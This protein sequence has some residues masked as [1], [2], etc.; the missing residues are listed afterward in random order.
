MLKSLGE[1]SLDKLKCHL[2]NVWQYETVSNDWKRG[3][4]VCIPKKG[5][6]R[7]CSNWRGITLLSVLEKI[8]SNI[9]YERINHE[10][11]SLMKEE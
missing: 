7:D 2:N 10:V 6:L 5:N 3:T 11:Q 1:A 9:V 4:I 8:L